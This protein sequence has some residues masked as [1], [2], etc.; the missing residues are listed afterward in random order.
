MVW[1]PCGPGELLT[2]GHWG[3]AGVDMWQRL[4]KEA[5]ERP[6]EA[7][8]CS[9]QWESRRCAL[10]DV[11]SQTEEP[12]NRTQEGGPCAGRPLSP[13]S[14]P[15]HP[16][17]QNPREGSGPAREGT[18]P[19]VPTIQGAHA[20]CVTS[21][22]RLPRGSLESVAGDIYRAWPKPGGQQ[23]RYSLSPGVSE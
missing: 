2:A 8:S 5:C 1:A 13:A 12:R 22:G 9:S 20:S 6:G 17:I 4:R 7:G 16:K 18:I 3:F 10:G 21:L 11:S 15:S 14:H 19:T 23:A